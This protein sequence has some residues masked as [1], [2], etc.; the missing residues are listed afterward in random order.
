MLDGTESEKLYFQN[1]LCVSL[2]S[3]MFKGLFITLLYVIA[4]KI[5]VLY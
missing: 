5:Y 1:Y 3:K 4:S 2:F